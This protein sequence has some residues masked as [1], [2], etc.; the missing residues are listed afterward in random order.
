MGG[1]NGLGRELGGLVSL[2]NRES[3]SRRSHSS[4][5]TRHPVS[6]LGDDKGLIDTC[7]ALRASLEAGY[8]NRICCTH[9]ETLFH[10]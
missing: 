10:W 9:K 6:S 2:W 8:S 3:R 4:L 5:S 7:A 1:E